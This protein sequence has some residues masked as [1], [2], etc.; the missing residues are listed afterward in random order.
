MTSQT[1]P[2]RTA[3]FLR[4]IQRD[5]SEPCRGSPGPDGYFNPPAVASLCGEPFTLPMSGCVRSQAVPPVSG[6]SCTDHVRDGG[7][8]GNLVA[9]CRMLRVHGLYAVRRPVLFRRTA[10]LNMH[11]CAVRP[12][13]ACLSLRSIA[14]PR[15]ALRFQGHRLGTVFSAQHTGRHRPK[16]KSQSRDRRN[17]G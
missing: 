8:R 12:P 16:E 3:A 6:A 9:V 17:V 1:P 5:Y 14:P 15:A 11:T 2:N 7:R 4:L 13:F 10:A